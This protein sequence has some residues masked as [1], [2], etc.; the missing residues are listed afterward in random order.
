MVPADLIQPILVHMSCFIGLFVTD[1][2]LLLN[3]E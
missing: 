3:L 1:M 2:Y